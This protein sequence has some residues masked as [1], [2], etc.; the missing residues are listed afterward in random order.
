M[1]LSR[2]KF[3]KTSVICKMTLDAGGRPSTRSPPGQLVEHSITEKASEMISEHIWTWKCFRIIVVQKS[4]KQTFT[5][6]QTFALNS[7]KNRQ[8]TSEPYQKAITLQTLHAP[9][10]YY[11]DNTPFTTKQIITDTIFELSDG[12]AVLLEEGQRIRH[13]TQLY[14]NLINNMQKNS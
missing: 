9:I 14:A 10:L 8:A 5:T 7:S 12:L 3:V 1:S 4:N 6:N 2:K 13:L 11:N